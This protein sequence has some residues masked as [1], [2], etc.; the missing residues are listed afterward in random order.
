MQKRKENLDK[1][2]AE[3]LDEELR[4]KLTNNHEEVKALLEETLCVSSMKRFFVDNY[5]KTQG[6]RAATIPLGISMKLFGSNDADKEI[7][8]KRIDDSEHP[9]I[10]KELA[11]EILLRAEMVTK[12]PKSKEKGASPPPDSTNTAPSTSQEAAIG[13]NSNA[14][15]ESIEPSS[16]D[17]PVKTLDEVKEEPMDVDYLKSRA[18]EEDRSEAEEGGG[19]HLG[20]QAMEEDNFLPLGGIAGAGTSAGNAEFEAVLSFF[21]EGLEPDMYSGTLLGD[22]MNEGF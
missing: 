9:A 18:A 16:E 7:I 1:K 5:K 6:K 20:A 17:Q 3:E 19:D 13:A 10:I 14:A 4:A 21:V 15:A 12:S 2:L 11:A 22:L 8:E